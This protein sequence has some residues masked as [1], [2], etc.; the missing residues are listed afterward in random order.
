V[1]QG[2]LADRDL[3]ADLADPDLLDPRGHQDQWDSLRV[4]TRYGVLLPS[5]MAAGTGEKDSEGKLGYVPARPFP[6]ILTPGNPTRNG[7]RS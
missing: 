1:D 6:P 7:G 2:D 3:P 4:R 5:R